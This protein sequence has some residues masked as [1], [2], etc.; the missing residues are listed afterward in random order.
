MDPFAVEAESGHCSPHYSR[1]PAFY[2]YYKEKNEKKKTKKNKQTP[3]WNKQKANRNKIQSFAGEFLFSCE[4]D[5]YRD[6]LFN[7]WSCP[8]HLVELNL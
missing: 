6:D 1:P 4:T 5:E 8:T 2:I 7:V 3:Q